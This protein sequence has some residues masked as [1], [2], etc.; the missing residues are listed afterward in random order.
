MVS[1]NGMIHYR[2]LV[3]LLPLFPEPCLSFPYEFLGSQS[4]LYRL[5]TKS[6]FIMR[7]LK[8]VNQNWLIDRNSEN[9][10]Y[11]IEVLCPFFGA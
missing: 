5:I 9:L 4:K 2:G 8:I 7:S 3:Y 6:Q 11:H 1:Y 10:E